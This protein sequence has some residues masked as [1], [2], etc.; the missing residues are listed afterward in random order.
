[1]KTVSDLYK[2]YPIGILGKVIFALFIRS[3]VA[4]GE[5]LKYDLL[6]AAIFVLAMIALS[7]FANK[8]NFEGRN[9]LANTCASI[10]AAISI[11]A[12]DSDGYLGTCKTKILFG[13]DRSSCSGT[14]TDGFNSY[15]DLSLKYGVGIRALLLLFIFSS[16]LYSI[17]KSETNTKGLLGNF[18]DSPPDDNAAR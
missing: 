16:F 12:V 17:V 13:S 1:M 14:G 15:L 6:F 9:S 7:F 11:F 8:V 2:R 3:L 18:E 4:R 10:Y 5:N